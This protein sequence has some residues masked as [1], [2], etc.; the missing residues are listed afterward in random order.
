MDI[1]R[2]QFLVTGFHLATKTL[3]DSGP[4]SQCVETGECAEWP[5]HRDSRGSSMHATTGPRAAGDWEEKDGMATESGGEDDGVEE[6]KRGS[7][8][9][10]PSPYAKLRLFKVWRKDSLGVAPGS[11]CRSWHPP[12]WDTPLLKILSW[13]LTAV[14]SKLFAGILLGFLF[15][16]SLCHAHLGYIF[17]HDPLQS[18]TIFPDHP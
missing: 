11:L 6:K 14:N 5:D 4:M 15:L 1:G 18:S 2:R 8:C 16:S 12:Q 9:C 7:A 17:F 13:L 10:R 3:V